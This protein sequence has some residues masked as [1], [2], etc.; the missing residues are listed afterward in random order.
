M[1]DGYTTTTPRTSGEALDPVQVARAEGAVAV[2]SKARSGIGAA[3]EVREA[4]RA[5]AAAAAEGMG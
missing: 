4:L 5:V 2:L 1:R 3:R